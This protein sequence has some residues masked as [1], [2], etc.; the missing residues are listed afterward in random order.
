MPRKKRDYTGWYE[1][2]Q[3]HV[4]RKKIARSKRRGQGTGPHG[5]HPKHDS[6]AHGHKSLGVKRHGSHECKCGRTI[7]LTKK[8][9]LGCATGRK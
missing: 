2:Y 3:A 8:R 1:R 9:C 5:L 7:S 4:L 6:F